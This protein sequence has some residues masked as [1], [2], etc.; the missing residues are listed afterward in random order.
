MASGSENA[1]A[2]LPEF[3]TCLDQRGREA[4]LATTREAIL[5]EVR[6]RRARATRRLRARC[7]RSGGISG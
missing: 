5:E 7:G 2:G 1:Y 3:W 6:F 4:L